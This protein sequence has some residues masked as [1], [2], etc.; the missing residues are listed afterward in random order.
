MMQYDISLFHFEWKWDYTLL[1]ILPTYTQ[2][3]IHSYVHDNLMWS[4]MHTITFGM[5]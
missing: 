4:C 5:K 3:W 2:N 1:I